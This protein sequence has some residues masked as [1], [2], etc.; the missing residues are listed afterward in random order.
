MYRLRI[1]CALLA[2]L[3]PCD[4]KWVE[5]ECF[6]PVG[7]RNDITQ[8]RK[9]KDRRFER[10]QRAIIGNGKSICCCQGVCST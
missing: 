2:P 9:L 3:N 10:G 8:G 4:K 5:T 7:A 1:D 6:G